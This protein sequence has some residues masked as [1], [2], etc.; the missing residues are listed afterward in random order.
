MKDHRR[1]R[2]LVKLC[3]FAYLRVRHVKYEYSFIPSALHCTIR[4]LLHGKTSALYQC[5]TA[6]VLIPFALPLCVDTVNR[7]AVLHHAASETPEKTGQTKTS[8][9]VR[10]AGKAAI[11]TQ[12]IIAAAT[13]CIQ[14][15]KTKGNTTAHPLGMKTSPCLD[16]NKHQ[17]QTMP[18]FK[19]SSLWN[20]VVSRLHVCSS[21]PT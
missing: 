21:P 13:S 4:V 9:T 12:D 16:S 11:V 10:R 8:L 7:T 5:Q 19:M 2:T 17:K 20:K 14:H 15:L 6:K 18:Y 1:G 3:V